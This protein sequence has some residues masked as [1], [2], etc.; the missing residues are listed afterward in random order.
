MS[1]ENKP[2]EYI[3][4]V[5]DFEEA[6]PVEEDLNLRRLRESLAPYVDMPKLR[7]LAAEYQDLNQALRSDAPPAQVRALIDALSALLRPTPHEQIKSPADAAALLMVQMGHL[8]QEE[9]RTVLLDTKNRVQD[10]VTVY[11]GSLNASLIRVGEVYKA[12]LRRNSASIILAHNHPSGEP[13]PPSPEDVLVT[14]KIVEAGELLD[15]A[16]LDHLVIGRGKWLSMRE[17]GLGF[18]R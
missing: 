7:Q 1:K 10:I 12:A 4:S 9:M 16:C 11:R 17:K 18:T 3:Q 14:V 2:V 5:L 8:D 6:Q 13:N 15:V